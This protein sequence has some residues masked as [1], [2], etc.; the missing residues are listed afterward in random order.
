MKVKRKDSLRLCILNFYPS[1]LLSFGSVKVYGAFTWSD[2]VIC[3]KLVE[4]C[5]NNSESKKR[6]LALQK[7]KIF[8][9]EIQD[10]LR[11]AIEKLSDGEYQDSQ[12]PKPV[13]ANKRWSQAEENQL[14]ESL[15]AGNSIELIAANLSRSTNS[16]FSRLHLLGV[17]SINSSKAIDIKYR[18][19]GS[20]E[21]NIEID[22]NRKCIEC[23]E[24]VGSKRLKKN[25]NF[26]RCESCQLAFELS[27][28]GA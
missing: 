11:F 24:L 5:M 27:R 14:I 28:K 4:I 21:K 18:D 22:L 12:I 9:L 16:V 15:L 19:V 26:Y 13:M 17:I 25:P 2:V 10:A 6:L 3:V 20:K 7:S 8:S 1:H 23:A